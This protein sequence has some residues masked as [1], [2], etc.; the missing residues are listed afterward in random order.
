MLLSCE[1]LSYAVHIFFF[2]AICDSF[3][4]C[5]LTGAGVKPPKPGKPLLLAIGNIW[6]DRQV[7]LKMQKH[8]SNTIFILLFYL[9]G[10]LHLNEHY[11]KYIV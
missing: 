8:G 10:T 7:P 1:F 9:G 6:L 4:M 2:F 11:Y 3:I 5:P